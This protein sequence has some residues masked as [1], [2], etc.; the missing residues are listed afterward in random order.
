[1][2]NLKNND[3]LYETISLIVDQLN[4]EFGRCK[5]DTKKVINLLVVKHKICKSGNV[6]ELPGWTLI[7]HCN[8]GLVRM[9]PHYVASLDN[10]NWIV[11]VS[12]IPG[13]R[14]FKGLGMYYSML[15]R[16]TCGFK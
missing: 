15:Q 12:Q 7:R 10:D 14:V 6:F 3:S 2:E 8:H 1:M 13:E 9:N 4:P 5:T 16:T 11:D